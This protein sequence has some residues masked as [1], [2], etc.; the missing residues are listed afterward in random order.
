MVF[1][2]S[3]QKLES[4]VANSQQK[5]ICLQNQWNASW[6]PRVRGELGLGV[7]LGVS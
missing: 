7:G 2:S 4:T 5:M 1:T 3:I 6:M